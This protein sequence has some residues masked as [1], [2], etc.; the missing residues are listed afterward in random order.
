MAME[1]QKGRIELFVGFVERDLRTIDAAICWAK[2]LCHRGCKRQKFFGSG[3][4]HTTWSR[5]LIGHI[6]SL[7]VCV[8]EV[9]LPNFITA[10]IA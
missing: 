1:A 2:P 9:S 7:F 8:F 6:V 5:K 10:K 4:K 3:V